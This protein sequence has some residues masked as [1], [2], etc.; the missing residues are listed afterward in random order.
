GHEQQV[1]NPAQDLHVRED[2]DLENRR[3][4]DE[5]GCLG[6]VDHFAAL[7]FF[8]RTC[9]LRSES[10]STRSLTW[11]CLYGSMSVWFTPTTVPTGIQRGNNDVTSPDF[12]PAVTS[13][14][15][16]STT[17]DFGTLSMIIELPGALC[18]RIPVAPVLGSM[19]E[20]ALVS[21]VTSFTCELP[22]DNPDTS[23]TRK[24]VGEMT[25]ELIFTPALRPTPTTMRWSNWP[26]GCDRIEVGRPV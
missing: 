13:G 24:P 19:I 16:S 9:T 26:G 11:I 6:A 12:H 7:C 22:A 10:R 21:S 2:R 5:R 25:G 8:T 15:P 18:R 3:Q 14:S 17:S 20:T 4:E 1:G 23:P